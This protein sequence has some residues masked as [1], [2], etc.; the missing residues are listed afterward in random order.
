MFTGIEHF[1]I[2][3]HDTAGLA[4]WYEKHLGFRTHVAIDNG[5]ETRKTYYI[6]VGENTSLIEIIPAKRDVALG[7]KDNLAPGISHIAILV[8]DFDGAVAAL[9][10]A[11]AKK[12]GAERAAPLGSRVQFYRDPE[13]NLFHLL[14]RPKPLADLI[15]NA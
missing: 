10:K 1:A 2:A 6:G 8:S 14:W 13:G 9:D 5:A 11:G 3:A 15:R 7:E 12:E 4:A